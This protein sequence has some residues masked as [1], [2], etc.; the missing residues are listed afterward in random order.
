MIRQ[1]RGRFSARRAEA[2]AGMRR[3]LTIL[4]PGMRMGERACIELP[5]PR[6]VGVVDVSPV[7]RT[8]KISTQCWKP[9]SGNVRR[10][11]S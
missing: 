5:G 10:L 1:W 11:G 6:T 2:C 4:A 7:H 9:L 3:I 8:A